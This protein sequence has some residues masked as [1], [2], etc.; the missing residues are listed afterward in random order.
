M[1]GEINVYIHF[2]MSRYP[3]FSALS[4]EEAICSP[5]CIFGF[6][7]GNRLAVAL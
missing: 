6:F 3:F 5:M 1:E 4:L 7:V 2:P